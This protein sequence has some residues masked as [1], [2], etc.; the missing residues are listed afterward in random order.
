[1]IY[2]T[3]TRAFSLGEEIW[4]IFEP[5]KKNVYVLAVWDAEWKSY[6][7]C[8]IILE[9]D[10]ITLLDCGKKEH[11]IYLIKA[12]ESLGKSVDDVTLLLATHGHEDHVQGA[13][14]FINAKKYI[15]ANERGKM[16]YP[17]PEQFEIL[18]S[19][20]N[21]IDDFDILLVG[22]HTPGSVA[23]YHRPSKVVFTGD[24]LCFFGDSL[25][26]DGLVSQGNDLR[27]AWLSFL[28]NGGVTGQ[29]L[30][31]FI[32]GLKGINRF[33]AD[34]MCSGH[35]GVLVGDITSFVSELIHLGQEW[36]HTVK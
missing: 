11:S 20:R 9:G 16:E 19:N 8:Y 1:M 15:H 33:D 13:E 23:F 14:I 6:N 31:I 4:I 32:E 26:K 25:S 22:D 28:H 24:F 29:H 18:P 3:F 5:I 21:N 2:R 10:Y 7:N 27:E 30:K 17:Y 12:L 36:L 35:G 34:A